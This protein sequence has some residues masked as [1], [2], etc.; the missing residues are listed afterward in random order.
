MRHLDAV[1][2]MQ[3]V[4]HARC[5]WASPGADGFERPVATK[6]VRADLADPGRFVAMLIEEG[7]HGAGC[8]IPT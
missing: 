3:L 5:F 8:L 1:Q 2:P 7:H 6:R 4:T